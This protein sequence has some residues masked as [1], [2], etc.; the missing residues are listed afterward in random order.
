MEKIRKCE[1]CGKE[2][3]AKNKLHKYCS[4][5]CRD[6]NRSIIHYDYI[7][8]YCGKEYSVDTKHRGKSELH[9]CSKQCVD[10]YH[11]QY[12]ESRYCVVCGKAFIP[13]R[14]NH[15]CCSK[16]CNRQYTKIK[17]DRICLVCGSI[18]HS[19]RNT[20]L[21]SPECKHTYREM[22]GEERQC[23]F[24][25]KTFHAMNGTHYFCTEKCKNAYYDHNMEYCELTCSHCGQT[26]LRKKKYM[27]QNVD[28]VFCSQK[29]KGEYYADTYRQ[30]VLH[31]LANGEFHTTMTTPHV[32]ISEYL[33]S[34]NVNHINEYVVSPFSADI[35]LNDYN[36]LIEI[37]G[38]YWHADS[39]RYKD[40]QL[41]EPQ[42]QNVG[43]DKR[44]HTFLLK[45]NYRV[46]YLWEWDII[47]NLDK[48]KL[49]I[50]EFLNNN[51]Q[52]THS[53]EYDLENFKLIKNNTIQYI[54]KKTN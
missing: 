49:L 37:M 31:K 45:N 10:N 46:L 16:K 35:K 5:S 22:S 24:C 40:D 43:R 54:Q 1:Y 8:S 52:S 6:R 39:R 15:V 51:M 50:D 21:C 12:N 32:I 36:I 14:S 33:N 2:F 28:V 30:N 48:C 53:S 7:C 41:N 19:D 42:Q 25:G 34:I 23:L 20:Y 44:K 4:V 38:G 13:T 29:C 3:I 26:F 17:K 9:F 47:N 18:F 11:K 27:S